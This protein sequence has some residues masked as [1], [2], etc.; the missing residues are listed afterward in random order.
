[1]RYKLMMVPEFQVP[2]DGMNGAVHIVTLPE[3]TRVLQVDAHWHM[4]EPDGKFRG[5]TR[6]YEWNQVSKAKES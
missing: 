2:S 6:S 1:M 3:G 5:G 4:D